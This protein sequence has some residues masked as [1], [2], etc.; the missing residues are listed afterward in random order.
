MPKV[1]ALLGYRQSAPGSGTDVLIAA[2]F[3]KY[4]HGIGGKAHKTVVDAW[5]Q[6]NVDR[7]ATNATALVQKE[8]VTDQCKTLSAFPTAETGEA[9]YIYYYITGTTV[10]TQ[11][12]TLP[13]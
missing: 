8:C 12:I 4:L 11:E 6:A 10:M 7:L 9:K 13:E 1:H 5:M 2:D 3:V